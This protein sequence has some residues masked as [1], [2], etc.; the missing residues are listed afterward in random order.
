V[1]TGDAA[2]RMSSMRFT[3]VAGLLLLGA[4]V[5][6]QEPR[7]KVAGLQGVTIQS[8]RRTTATHVAQRAA[9]SD[10]KS[11]MRRSTASVTLD[12]YASQFLQR[13][14]RLWSRSRRKF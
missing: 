11:Q 14:A 12:Y 9:I 1:L 6:A 8:L 7:Q 10:T 2:G 13:V 5:D 4:N 3:A